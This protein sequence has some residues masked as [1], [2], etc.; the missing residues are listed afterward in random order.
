MFNYFL[1]F[2]YHFPITFFSYLPAA[3]LIQSSGCTSS[4]LL[5]LSPS[6]CPVFHQLSLL[7]N[8]ARFSELPPTFSS[9]VQGWVRHHIAFAQGMGLFVLKTVT[10]WTWR[11][12]PFCLQLARAAC[13]SWWSCA[14]CRH[15]HMMSSINL[16]YFQLRKWLP[17]TNSLSARFSSS[18][19]LTSQHRSRCSCSAAADFFPSS[20]LVSFPFFVFGVGGLH[21]TLSQ[22]GPQKKIKVI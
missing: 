8:S 1:L 15:L 10:K 18:W 3:V 12:K 6:F 9:W 4:S 13:S 17:C 14:C 5:G 11:K 7:Q 2:Y 16:L 21:F 19:A 20:A 22:K